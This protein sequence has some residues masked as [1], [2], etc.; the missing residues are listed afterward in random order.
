[1]TTSEETLAA[2]DAWWNGY[3]DGNRDRPFNPPHAAG[4]EAVR[5]YDEGFRV[6]DRERLAEADT[7]VIVGAGCG[8]DEIPF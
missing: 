5:N 8:D 6:G 2:A 7:P 1:M 4:A 3:A